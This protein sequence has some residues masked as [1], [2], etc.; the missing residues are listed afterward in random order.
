[1]KSGTMC[2]LR[3]SSTPTFE[4]AFTYTS[5]QESPWIIC[6]RVV[7]ILDAALMHDTEKATAY[8]NLLSV[9]A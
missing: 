5:S 9:Q 2:L 7:K 4:T 1:M 8:A 6:L 3:V